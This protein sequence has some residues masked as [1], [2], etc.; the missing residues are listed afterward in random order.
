MA[1]GP[2]R[3]LLKWTSFAVSLSHS[4]KLFPSFSCPFLPSLCA[5]Y[6]FIFSMPSL[7]I[8][9]YHFLTFFLLTVYA[10]FS[11][12]P[13]LFAVSIY[14]SSISATLPLSPLL[15]FSSFVSNYNYPHHSLVN[16]NP[17]IPRSLSAHFS[18]S[19]YTPDIHASV[20]PPSPYATPNSL[21]CLLPLP[22]PLFPT[23]L[24]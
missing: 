5:S 20:I 10:P 3:S 23:P 8:S 17:L 16:H 1:S 11:L 6:T 14:L 7:F 9:P 2:C 4:F 18:P 22:L 13:R 15:L 12:S 21:S 24:P 19:L